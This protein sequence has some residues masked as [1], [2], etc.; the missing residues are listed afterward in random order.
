[1]GVCGKVAVRCGKVIAKSLI[2]LRVG[3]RGLRCGVSPIPPIGADAPPWRG[4]M[5]LRG[6]RAWFPMS[7]TERMKNVK[8]K[9]M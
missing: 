8:V 9:K 4:V 6:G 7:K 2:L 1:M 3:L 5:P